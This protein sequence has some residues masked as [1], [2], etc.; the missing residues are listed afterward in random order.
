MSIKNSGSTCRVFKAKL[1][2]KDYFSYTRYCSEYFAL[3]L[4]SHTKELFIMRLNSAY[5]IQNCGKELRIRF[6][7]GSAYKV[8]L[9]SF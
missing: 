5:D 7:M 6:S 8:A 3:R 9:M 4:Q 2:R 1:I